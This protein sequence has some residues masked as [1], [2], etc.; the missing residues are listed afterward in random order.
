M[1]HLKKAAL[2]FIPFLLLTSCFIADELFLENND[3]DQSEDLQK[4]AEQ[5]VQT[6]IKSD[7]SDEHIYKPYGFSAIKIIKP[8]PLAELEQLEIDVKNS[9]A[10]STIKREYEAKKAL[11]K[12]REIRRTIEIEHFFTVQDDSA[13][14]EVIEATY[15]LN[16]TFG[17]K[18]HNL[19]A[20]LP[21]PVSYESVLNY[22]FNEYTIFMART[23]SEGRKLSNQF[24]KFFKTELENREGMNEKSAF[25]RHILDICA[26]VMKTGEFNQNYMTRSLVEHY[27]RSQREDIEAY[28]P[29]DYTVLYES[30]QEDSNELIGYYFFHKFSGTYNE[31]PDTNVVLVEFSPFYEVS[32]VFQMNQPFEYY[33][34]PKE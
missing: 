3:A 25:L 8:L 1:N 24:Y 34:K 33:N 2:L 19:Q 5:A 26:V 4:K 21:I 6:Y 14:I 30:R 32:Q 23:Y 22:Y 20:Y 10:D 18:T 11:V 27:I 12:E 9:P 7:Y 29:L 16:D 17:V 13:T 15:F 31:V 28:E